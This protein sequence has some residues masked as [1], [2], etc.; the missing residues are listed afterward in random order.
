MFTVAAPTET[1]ED[2][3]SI[4]RR[5]HSDIAPNQIGSAP[6]SVCF[7]QPSLLGTWTRL[8]PRTTAVCYETPYSLYSRPP[9]GPKVIRA[10]GAGGGIGG[11]F[12]AES[13]TVLMTPGGALTT[14]P[15][16]N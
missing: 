3:R 8:A 13:Y 2:G 10:R 5:Y 4:D 14:G 11:K 1:L 9:K 16:V 12:V 15:A 6:R 7:F